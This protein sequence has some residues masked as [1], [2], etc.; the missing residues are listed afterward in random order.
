MDIVVVEPDPVL[1]E[2]V[3]RRH[4]FPMEAEGPTLPQRCRHLI[5]QVHR[6]D[7]FHLHRRCMCRRHRQPPTDPQQ[8]GPQVHFIISD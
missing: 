5:C 3:G 8:G 2:G 1:S 7:I 6:R 4:L